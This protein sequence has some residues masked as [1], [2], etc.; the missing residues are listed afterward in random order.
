MSVAVVVP[1]GGTC[2]YRRRAWAWVQARYAEAHPGWDLIQAG[3]PAEKWRKGAAVNPA[4]AHCRAEIVVLADADV[5]TEGLTAAV[6]A[7]D[8]GAAWAMPHYNLHR[9]SEE[10]TSA[11]LAGADWREQALDDLDG[12]KPYRGIMGGGV[13]VARR[14]TL[15]E[16]PVDER[17]T[18]WGQEDECHALALHTL[19]G[20]AW[21]GN[22]DLLHLYHPP[23]PRMTRRR[24]SPESW[25][26]RVRYF[27]LRDDPGA[28]RALLEEFR[29]L[30]PS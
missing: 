9:L 2:P 12:K 4:V 30:S 6:A 13:L 15:E 7:V 1:Y 26:L 11:V 10:G 21:R 17:F 18:G 19:A 8:D 25:A 14:E 24:G 28:L 22:A 5:W 23:M 20:E 29:C 3:V 16:I 27:A